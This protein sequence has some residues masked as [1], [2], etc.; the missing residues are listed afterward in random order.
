VDVLVQLH[1]LLFF[2]DHL[3]LGSPEIEIGQLTLTV[4]TLKEIFLT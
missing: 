1:L 3:L 2:N 4:L